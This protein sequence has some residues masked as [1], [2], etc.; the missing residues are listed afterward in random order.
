MSRTG[1]ALPPAVQWGLFLPRVV[2]GLIVCAHG[3]WK[4][5]LFAGPG[6]TDFSGGVSGLG[7]PAP[8]VVAVIWA[9][10]EVMAGLG[11]LVGFGTRLWALLYAF[12]A[13]GGVAIRVNHGFFLPAGIEYKLLLAALSLSYALTGAQA[14]A[15]DVQ[16]KNR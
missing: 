4:F 15:M 11:L 6:L 9:S 7:V 5:G 10:V 8:M 12:I 16:L 1:H 3:L 14:I 13:V 2:L